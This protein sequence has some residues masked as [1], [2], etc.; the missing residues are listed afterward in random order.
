MSVSDE[1]AA[2]RQFVAK[3]PLPLSKVMSRMITEEGERTRCLLF[4]NLELMHQM[5]VWAFGA[6]RRRKRS[7]SQPLLAVDVGADAIRVIDPA[8]YSVAAGDWLVLVE[9]FGLAL[10]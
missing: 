8:D 5:S 2:L 7:T 4:P 3:P 10:G 6:K 9:K 1:S